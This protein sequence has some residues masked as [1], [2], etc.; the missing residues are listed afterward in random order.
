MLVYGLKPKASVDRALDQLRGDRALLKQREAEVVRLLVRL[1]LKGDL[2][3]QRLGL[4][5]RLE[6]LKVALRLI[7][8]GVL[9][10]LREPQKQDVLR[11]RAKLTRLTLDLD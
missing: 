4:R 7:E 5:V 6:A 8:R 2:N 1:A 9:K 10:E 11:D 3:P